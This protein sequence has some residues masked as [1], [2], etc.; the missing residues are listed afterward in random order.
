MKRL[1]NTIVELDKKAFGVIQRLKGVYR[2]PYFTLRFLRIQGSPG[3]HPASIAE[4][5][6][7]DKQ[8]SFPKRYFKDV[9]SKRAL[10][11]FLIRRFNEG[12]RHFAKQ[13]RGADGSGSFHTIELSQIMVER[14]AV[15]VG[16]DK[17]TLR[18]IVS[19]PSRSMGGGSFDASEAKTMLDQELSTICDYTFLYDRFDE[20]TKDLLDSFHLVL[21]DRHLI[22]QEMTEKGWVCFIP[23]GAVLP[24]RSGVDERPLEEDGVIPFQAP[25]SMEVEIKLKNRS[26]KGMALKEGVSVV[27]GGGFH[28][29]ST[30]L[31]AIT[32]GVY[33][34]IPGD[35]RERVVTR[36]DAVTIKSEEGR[37]VRNVDIHAFIKDL[38]GG[39]DTAHFSTDNASGSTSQASSIIEA[40]EVGSKLLLFDEDNCAT[41]FLVRDSLIQEIIPPEREPIKPLYDAARSLWEIYGVSSVLVIGGLGIFLKKADCVLLL[42]EYKCYDVTQKVR[43]KIGFDGKSENFQ[44]NMPK[45]R[46]LSKENF[47]PSFENER[48]RKRVPI[49]IKPLRQEPRKLEYGM[50]LIDLK[51]IDQ[52]VEAPQTLAIG[53]IV[54]HLHNMLAQTEEDGAELY[55]VLKQLMEKIDEEGLASID[56]EYP[57][58]ISKPRIFEVAA[59]INRM[60]SLKIL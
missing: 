11:E 6:L 20:S 9:I 60:R 19:F 3:A 38:P 7:E 4:I 35:G 55:G 56:N 28:G 37:S 16:D 2:Y 21:E 44:F 48:L 15:A 36:E 24:R 42:D 30:L 10:S 22:T 29:K 34:H 39:K 13:N 27:T 49:R 23:N 31:Q 26:I 32:E 8:I 50:D 17:I 45:Q 18:F 40:L 57:G 41:N 1:F 25:A 12:V 5:T 52:L 59:A 46:M 58:T 51:A 47:D 33:A 53:R 43:S 14:D 54:F